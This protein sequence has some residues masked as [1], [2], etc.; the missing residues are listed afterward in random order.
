MR[1]LLHLP[2]LLALHCWRASLAG[3]MP[4][5]A[6]K[7]RKSDRACFTKTVTYARTGCSSSS[8]RCHLDYMFVRPLH[9]VLCRPFGQAVRPYVT[10]YNSYF[11]V[12]I[13]HGLAPHCIIDEQSWPVE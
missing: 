4:P 6:L 3:A 5:L 8:Y 11:S 7:V 9:R 2:S 12:E 1:V 13:D 10:I